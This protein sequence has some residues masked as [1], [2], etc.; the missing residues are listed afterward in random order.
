MTTKVLIVED[1]RRTR[2]LLINMLDTFQLDLDVRGVGTVV[3]AIRAIK[4]FQPAIVILDIHLPDGSG[5]DVLDISEDLD[6]KIIFSTAHEEFAIKA[7]KSAAFDYLLKPIDP[8]ELKESIS[9]AIELSENSIVS[10]VEVLK[11]NMAEGIPKKI[12]LHT[13][14]S[15]FVVQ[16]DDLVRCESERNYTT[17]HLSDGRKIITSKTIKDYDVLLNALPFYRCHR[18]HILNFDYFDRFDK[19]EGGTI[20][21]KNNHQIPL[22]R[23]NRDAFFSILEE[24]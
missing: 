23:S 8:L 21:M 6:F 13:S 2:E 3:S 11:E 19:K 24:L 5:F 22:A 7:I 14:D 12:V 9:K 17:F 18:S 1:E 15:I 16:T 20:I 4:E 10:A